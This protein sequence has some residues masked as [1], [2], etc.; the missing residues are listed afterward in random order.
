[1]TYALQVTVY[2]VAQVKVVK[3]VHRIPQLR[4][5]TLKS[6]DVMVKVGENLL[7]K[8]TRSTP[9]F[10]VTYSVILLFST[11]LQM[12]LNGGV[13]VGTPRKGTMFGCCNLFHI[14]TSL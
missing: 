1:M 7:T 3:A 5:L 9:G 12:I 8:L 11:W 4:S 6:P 2:H 14:T 10:F 13:F